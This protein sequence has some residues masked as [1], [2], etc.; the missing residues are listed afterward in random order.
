MNS[1]FSGKILESIF[2]SGIK[3][4]VNYKWLFKTISRN[5]VS[6]GFVTEKFVDNLS[7]FTRF[8]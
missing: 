4:K 7:N 5:S 6:V 8:V 3:S 2:C 1:N